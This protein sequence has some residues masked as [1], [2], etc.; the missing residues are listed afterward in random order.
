GRQHRHPVAAVGVAVCVPAIALAG[1]HLQA[2]RGAD[3]IREIEVPVASDAKVGIQLVLAEV[4]EAG[5]G[6][7]ARAIA[8][9][10]LQESLEKTHKKGSP[11]KPATSTGNCPMTALGHCVKR[12]WPYM[13]SCASQASA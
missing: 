4:V 5:P 9:H 13:P 12:S 8:Q 7:P 1:D 10:T 3:R 6:H 2:D 11:P